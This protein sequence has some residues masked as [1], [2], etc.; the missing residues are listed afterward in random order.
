MI[1]TDNKE[2]ILS[3]IRIQVAAEVRGQLSSIS[4]EQGSWSIKQAVELAIC[5]GIEKAIG[6]LIEK[7]YLNQDFEK[8][9]GL[10]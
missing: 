6:I 2:K 8:D 9:L 7:T 10:R 3:D 5:Q 4:L 1:L